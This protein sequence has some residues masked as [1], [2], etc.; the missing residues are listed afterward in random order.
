MDAA[1]LAGLFKD[2]MCGVLCT[3]CLKGNSYAW[4]QALAPATRRVA[5][6]ECTTWKD[7]ILRFE[8]RWA[9]VTTGQLAF[10]KRDARRQTGSM[11]EYIRAYQEVD[12]V[13][14]PMSTHPP[15]LD[16]RS[17]RGVQA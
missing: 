8:K 16:A 3:Q 2:E 15:A 12:A 9:G 13:L 10:E 4:Y 7:F 1:Y 5:Y 11:M 6:L 14:A 17:D